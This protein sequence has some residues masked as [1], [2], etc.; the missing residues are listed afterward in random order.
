M[1]V[2]IF[3]QVF[4]KQIVYSGCQQT[5]VVK[6]HFNKWKLREKQFSA[7]KLTSKDQISKSRG[8]WSASSDTHAYM[9]KRYLK[10]IP[11]SRGLKLILVEGQIGT[12]NI[13]QG[14]LYDADA[15][16]ADSEP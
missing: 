14:P 15:T 11:N 12:S 13:I 2:K 4:T 7:W 3:S 8:P 9:Y 16:M 10:D 5:T 6:F 1:G